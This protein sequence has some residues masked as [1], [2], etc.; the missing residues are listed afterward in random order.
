MYEVTLE[1]PVDFVH[2]L[3]SITKC[4]LFVRFEPN[5]N[6]LDILVKTALPP[7]PPSAYKVPQKS[8]RWEIGCAV[9]TD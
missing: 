3:V 1:A 9:H 7:H 8:V 4:L 2:Y 5:L 6:L